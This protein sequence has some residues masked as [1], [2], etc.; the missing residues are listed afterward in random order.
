MIVDLADKYSDSMRR[1]TWARVMRRLGSS[2]TDTNP[3]L[4]S[5]R[6][7][8]TSNPVTPNCSICRRRL[9]AASTTAVPVEKVAAEPAVMGAWGVVSV[10]P[11]TTS[12]SLQATPNT[13]AAICGSTVVAPSPTSMSPVIR[14]M[15]P[16]RSIR[17][18]AEESDPGPP[19]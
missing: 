2:L 14:A 5:S 17:T 11:L 9:A 4:I 18:S 12:M 19:R 8:G 3:S 10:S 13:S 6:S 16:D 7:A 1:T 15:R